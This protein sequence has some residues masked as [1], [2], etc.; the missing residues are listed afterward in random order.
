MQFVRRIVW[1]CAIPLAALVF[2]LSA[3]AGMA[4]AATKVSTAPRTNAQS[5]SH[6]G[7]SNANDAF[8][9]QLQREGKLASSVHILSSL[10]QTTIVQ[11]P[12][13]PSGLKQAFPN[14]TG[15]VTIVRGDR[16][17]AFS[18][19]IIVDVQHMPPNVTF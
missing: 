16:N 5:L 2:I 12:L 1:K 15:L 19:T 13:V 10:G 9:R 18:D 6:S 14:A 4:S 3:Q 7:D 8:L 17:N 11:F